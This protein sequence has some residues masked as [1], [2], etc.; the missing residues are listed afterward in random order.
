MANV[1]GGAMNKINS[2]LSSLGR[3]TLTWGNEDSA[4]LYRGIRQ[5]L[6][7][8]AA[9]MSQPANSRAMRAGGK[10]MSMLAST[11]AAQIGMMDVGV[12]AGGLYGGY[13]GYQDKRSV[14]GV[15]S[16][17]GAG[18]VEGKFLG[19]AGAG[20]MGLWRFLPRK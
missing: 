15:V 5:T 11:S 6:R 1:F 19:A 2:G 14:G 9:E 4:H 3:H 7:D 20:A 12:A 8:Q 13:R 18:M 17:A 16:G 10:A